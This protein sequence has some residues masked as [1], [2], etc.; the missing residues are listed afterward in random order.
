MS[1]AK[2]GTVLATTLAPLAGLHDDAARRYAVAAADV[3]APEAVS[4]ALADADGPQQIARSCARFG[5]KFGA[6]ESVWTER[7]SAELERRGHTVAARQ[8]PVLVATVRAVP[9]EA[10]TPTPS[11]G[12]T[13]TPA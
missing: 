13:P 7:A 3:L 8:L 12:M 1:E 2:A 10:P 5:A 6:H 4:C 11:E 9:V